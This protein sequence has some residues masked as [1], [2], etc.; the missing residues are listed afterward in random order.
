MRDNIIWNTVTSSVPA[1]W[2]L[3][4]DGTA[5]LES[6]RDKDTRTLLKLDE[7]LPSIGSP[8]ITL[9]AM[10]VLVA[11]SI[12]LGCLKWLEVMEKFDFLVEDLSVGIIA[13]EK[14]RFCE[15]GE[16]SMSV[17]VTQQLIIYV[18]IKRT[19]A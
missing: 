4:T 15:I 8:D 6:L 1:S 7:P 18:P 14:L 10:L 3:P 16:I 5:E 9:L 11:L 17:R 13:A 2:D 19:P 12:C